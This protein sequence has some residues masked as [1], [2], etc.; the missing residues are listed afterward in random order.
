MFELGKFLERKMNR[1]SFGDTIHKSCGIFL[2]R[3]PFLT[4]SFLKIPLSVVN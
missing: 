3:L 1:F 4:N 2:V